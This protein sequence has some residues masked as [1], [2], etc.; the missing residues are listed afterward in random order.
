MLLYIRSITFLLYFAVDSGWVGGLV[1]LKEITVMGPG[2][3]D[4]TRALWLPGRISFKGL[5]QAFSFFLFLFFFFFFVFLFPL[6]I[7][8]L[9]FL[10]FP[11]PFYFLT[12]PFPFMYVLSILF[13]FFGFFSLSPFSLSSSSWQPSSSGTTGNNNY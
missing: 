11:F 1:Q 2:T 12:F 8:S 10:I 6:F 13:N 5:G 9:I 4:P 7:S 3:A